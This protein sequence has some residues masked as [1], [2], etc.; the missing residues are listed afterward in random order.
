MPG[1]N[2]FLALSEHASSLIG[3]EIILNIAFFTTKRLALTGHC[4]V[5]MLPQADLFSTEDNF[6]TSGR[7][8]LPLVGVQTSDLVTSLELEF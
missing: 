3:R 4:R 7:Q 1:V 2:F 5:D 8:V 6:V